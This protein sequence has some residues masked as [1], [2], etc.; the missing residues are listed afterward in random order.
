MHFFI[1]YRNKLLRFIVA[2]STLIAILV[3]C[4]SKANAQPYYFKHFQ[5]ENGLSNN[6]VSF[7]SQDSKGFMWFA[8]KDG[9]NRFDGFHFKVF[10]MDNVE[11]KKNLSTD[12]IFCILPGIDGS[13]W[14]GSQ[15]G[16]YKYDPRKERL[17]TI[18]DS[19]PNIYD[20]T[21]DR[22]GQMWFI[23]S[24]TLCRLDLKTNSLKQ[25]SPSSYFYAS[26]ICLSKE[27]DIWAATIEGILKKFDAASETFKSYDVFAHS[28]TPTSRFIQKIH[29]GDANSLFIGTISQGLKRFNID[30]LTY[31]DLLTYNPDNT[32]IFVRDILKNTE[33]EYWFATES[34]IFIYHTDTGIFTN[35]KKKFDDPYSLNDNAIYALCKDAEGS[36]WAGTF[37]G[38]VNYYAKQNAVFRKYLPG[39]TENAISG[40]AVREICKDK[41]GNLWLGT[42]DGGLNEIKSH[43]NTLVHFKPTGDET[44]ITYSNIHGLLAYGD[45][46]WI[47]TFEHGIDIMD[48]RTGKIKKHFT[49]GPGE[50]DLK[51]NFALCFLRTSYGEILVGSSNGLYSY[52]YNKDDFER[53]PQ[54]PGN[55]L[56]TSLVEDHHKI[57]WAGT[58]NQGAYWFDPGTHVSGHV[59]NELHNTNSLSN[60]ALND[61]YED[62]NN[63]IWFSTEGGGLCQLSSDRKKFTRYAVKDGLPSN[64]LFKVLEDDNKKLWASTSRGL[65]SFKPG[66]Q[67]ITVYTRDNGLLNDQFNYHSGY[68]DEDGRL[69]F[70]SVKGMISFMPDD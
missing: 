18:I 70:G 44:S 25:Y 59:Q 13:L 5:V 67:N 37:F 54:V 65:V 3:I 34:G 16:L 11:D 30:S 42:E 9:L 69:Y 23:S 53:V 28:K 33:H 8:T 56:I 38:G 47:G 39:N 4:A 58:N 10:R 29:A 40:N 17:E 22:Q 24:S 2:G 6:T 12:Y 32:T 20:I 26:T 55:C 46:L 60:N 1:S 63:T 62:S 43:T 45:D 21:F 7:V 27:G 51:S 41:Y 61:V 57:I 48:I 19:L 35:L 66:F 15:G 52:N 68:K 49:A 64:F 36:I 14:V 31:T 50:R